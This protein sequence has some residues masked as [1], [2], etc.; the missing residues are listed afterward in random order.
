MSD[1]QINSIL[2][3]CKLKLHFFCINVLKL[4][5]EN[6]V[7]RIILNLFM[8]MLNIFLLNLILNLS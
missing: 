7:S 6:A 4:A 8:K 3:D 5:S 2:H 1:Y